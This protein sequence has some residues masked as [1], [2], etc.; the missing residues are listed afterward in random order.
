MKRYPVMTNGALLC[1]LLIMLPAGMLNSQEGA[2]PADSVQAA[3]EVGS[4]EAN[5]DQ[6]PGRRYG[7]WP[8]SRRAE[9]SDAPRTLSLE[10]RNLDI[11]NLLKFYSDTFKWTVVKDPNCTGPVTIICPG[12]V[13]QGEALSVLN[14]VLEVR[15]FT[16]VLSGSLLKIVPLAR[17]VQSR[18]DIRVG[19]KPEPLDVDQVITQIVPLKQ[20]QAANLQRELTP[21]VSPGASLIA[22]PASNTLIITDTGS[23]VTRLLSIIAQLDTE[24]PTGTRVFPLEFADA[25]ALATTIGRLVSAQATGGGAPSPSQP[26]RSRTP[27][28][29]LSPRGS[30]TARSA[31]GSGPAIS[32]AT[33]I[34]DPRT[35]SLIVTAPP[36][37]MQVAE[38]VI[39]SLDKEVPYESTTYVVSLQNAKAIDLAN[40]LNR[41]FYQGGSARVAAP[42]AGTRTTGTRGGTGSRQRTQPGLR[43]GT[44]RSGLPEE[45]GDRVAAPVADG[46]EGERDRAGQAYYQ[47]YGGGTYRRGTYGG[48][49]GYYGGY[50]YPGYGG[51][52]GQSRAE[53]LIVPEPNTNS[54]IINAPPEQIA[55]VK[56]LIQ[57]LD[58]VPVQVLIQ[59][60]IVEMNLDDTSKLG[61]EWNWV[62]EHALGNPDLTG[63]ASATFGIDPKQQGFRYSLLGPNFSTVISALATDRR[64]N[65]LSTPRIFTANNQAAEINISQRVPYIISSRETENG[66]I[67]YNYGYMD[68]GIVLDV[69][70]QVSSNGTVNLVVS[71]EAND[72]IGY[73]TFNAP[74]VA[75]R[76]A[77]T[78]VSIQD[79]QTVVLGGIMKESRTQTTSKV[80]ILGDLPLIGNLFRK[81]EIEKGKTELMVFMTPH[82]VRSPS[83]AQTLTRQQRDELKGLKCPDPS[84]S[85]KVGPKMEEPA[86]P[87]P[88]EGI[89]A[90]DH[91]PAPDENGNGGQGSNS[92]RYDSGDDSSPPDNGGEGSSGEE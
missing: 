48:G 81:K 72:L 28:G 45:D 54:L 87:P 8:R 60:V 71:Q 5:G 18:V 90:P 33:V 9:N 92:D 51:Y 29:R 41:I 22:S 7:G 20:A 70:P 47:P 37:K 78:S 55:S 89:T 11:D 63:T 2:P 79:G 84:L 40:T 73:T 12:R 3:P 27:E 77:Q 67:S 23:N 13:N 46:D 76:S 34:A 57:K 58:Q 42:T 62:E 59:V 56:D 35:N 85:I 38:T 25:S 44:T 68:V 36:D 10:V 19:A 65:I 80:P 30:D 64:A 91:T 16:S 53:V 49:S 43:G 75:Q 14:G 66:T 83:E 4:T 69:T 82:V 39:K 21:L 24:Q 61:V 50:G 52:G 86:L 6:A 88:G 17:A 1:L 32:Q 26:S 15:G 31:A 74:I